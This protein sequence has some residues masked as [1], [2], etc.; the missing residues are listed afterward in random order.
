MMKG[1][2]KLAK[3]SLDHMASDMKK[4]YDWKTQPEQEYKKG[5]Q[6]L[7]E[8]T[9]IRSDCPSKKLDNK[10]FGP[11]KILEKV[12]RS[13]YKLK[14]DLKWH[15]VHPVFH[16]PLLHPYSIPSLASQKKPPLPPPDLIQGVEEQEIEEIL[17]SQE[18]H[19][20]IEYLISW[21]GF[22]SEENEWIIAS[23]MTHMEDA[24]KDFHQTHPTVPHPQKQMQ[25]QYISSLLHLFMFHLS[26][27]YHSEP[28]MTFQ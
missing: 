16:K 28:S 19:R 12:G 9:N 18:R 7:L 2:F 3:E 23:K 27:N 8:G 26:L 10:R 11:F 15:G 17:A 1:T 5:D 14:L 13:T 4:Y 21:K 25:L 22:P 24:I 6:V 20:K